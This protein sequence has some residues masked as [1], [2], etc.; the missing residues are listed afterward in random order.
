HGPG[1][2]PGAAA[3]LRRHVL[4]LADPDEVAMGPFFQPDDRGDRR[5]ALG[6]AGR[7]GA[8]LAA[9]GRGRRHE[10]APVRRRRDDLPAFRAALRGHDLM[11][12]SIEA[13]GLSK[14]YEIGQM[15]AAYGTLRESLTRVGKKMVG[16]EEE[17]WRGRE[18]WALRDVSFK[19]DTGEV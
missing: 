7:R 3:D 19:V 15:K 9:H 8:Q 10:C 12:V 5:V 16:R 17:V 2:P 11:S 13:E 4:D 6:R 18:I 1:V 14:R